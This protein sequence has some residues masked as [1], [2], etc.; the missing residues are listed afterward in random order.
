[1]LHFGCEGWIEGLHDTRT[2]GEVAGEH[3]VGGDEELENCRV[4]RGPEGAEEACSALGGIT[5]ARVGQCLRTR[6]SLAYEGVRKWVDPAVGQV[7]ADHEVVDYVQDG[8]NGV[9]P[10]ELGEKKA[11]SEVAE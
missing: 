9:C 10:L 1:M 2:R 4:V 6:G 7:C 5:A 3:H 8:S 11:R